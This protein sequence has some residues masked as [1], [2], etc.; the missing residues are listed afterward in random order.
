MSGTIYVNGKFTRQP[1]TGVQRV[2]GQLVRALD[3]LAPRPDEPRWV[4][5][6]PPGG[7]LG[8]LGRI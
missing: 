2:A 5:L 7:G 8:G 3:A 4:L 1:T 6:H